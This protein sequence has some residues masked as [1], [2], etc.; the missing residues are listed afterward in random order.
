[1]FLSRAATAK[2]SSQQT[3]RRAAIAVSANA[4]NEHKWQE[5]ARDELSLDWLLRARDFAG[6]LT[7]LQS[8]KESRRWS[9]G[10][11][12][13]VKDGAALSDTELAM[14]LGYAAFH[15]GDFECALAAYKSAGEAARLETACCMFHLGMLRQA[16]ELAE[17][18]P[19][20]SLR[21]RL[22]L[23]I[24]EQ[25]EEQRMVMQF[26]EQLEEP[27][28]A[29]ARQEEAASV[30]ESDAQQLAS[31]AEQLCL[32]AVYFARR[33]FQEAA[34]V[35]KKVLVKHRSF[36]ALQ[37]YIAMC[38]FELDYHDV[39]N[40]LLQPF[41]DATPDSL[42]ALNLKS[43]NML[44]LFDGA[45]AETA[46]RESVANIVRASDSSKEKDGEVSSEAL[47]EAMARVSENDVIRHNLVV[48]REGESALQVLPPLLDVLPEARLNLITYHLRSGVGTDQ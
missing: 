39:S 20:S 33:Q 26:I 19:H 31:V 3:T 18:T 8:Q 38:Y 42:L 29:M 37:V 34:D 17:E 35:Y 43:C 48:F 10:R 46:L 45:T 44:R 4:T 23:H 1:M 9:H 27:K 2:S 36:V 16:R 47:E 28:E 25:R 15:L 24:A 13:N 32:A 41:L 11:I 7:L 5:E 22:L 40:Q 30:D 12:G 6:A 21:T 14:W